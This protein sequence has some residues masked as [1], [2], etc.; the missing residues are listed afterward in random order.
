V[1]PDALEASIF[2]ERGV[3][4][5][6]TNG[7]PPKSEAGNFTLTADV[8][9]LNKLSITD[10]NG[11][12]DAS[13]NGGQAKPQKA[14]GQTLMRRCFPPVGLFLV[15]DN[16]PDDAQRQAA[17]EALREEIA[18]AVEA[19]KDRIRV[20]SFEKARGGA[21]VNILADLG[22]GDPRSPMQL[23]CDLV[24]QARD[25]HSKLRGGS[26]SSRCKEAVIQENPYSVGPD[27]AKGKPGSGKKP[28]RKATTSHTPGGGT[29]SP[30]VDG[31]NGRLEGAHDPPVPARPSAA[32][33][34]IK[35]ADPVKTKSKSET[36]VP[37]VLEEVAERLTAW[38]QTAEAQQ[39]MAE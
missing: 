29:D 17:L 24:A 13:P 4:Q 34:L 32:H 9:T 12:I 36:E 35:A 7:H 11:T 6:K 22:S 10:T 19:A 5:P 8:T 15:M 3:S 1:S 31:H 39:R 23:A 33:T 21:Q 38:L 30:G 20:V 27:P 14:D 25:G 28:S 2:S 18:V 26:L 16:A 37:K